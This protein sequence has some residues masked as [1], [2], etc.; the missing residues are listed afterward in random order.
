MR[1]G[2]IPIPSSRWST[3]EG[4]E[5]AL[6]LLL[7]ALGLDG[8]GQVSLASQALIHSF[9]DTPGQWQ[10]RRDAPSQYQQNILDRTFDA[11]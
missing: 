6:S 2:S 7:S 10:R 8:N 5:E 3:V 9:G 1:T 4:R 11:H